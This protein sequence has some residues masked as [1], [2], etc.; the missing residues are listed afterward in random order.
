MR[1]KCRQYDYDDISHD[2]DGL[3][4][5]HRVNEPNGRDDTV[6]G[7][8]A[9]VERDEPSSECDWPGEEEYPIRVSDGMPAAGHAYDVER[10]R[11]KP[12]YHQHG[13]DERH[14]PR[15]KVPC[16]SSPRGYKSG[17]LQSAHFGLRMQELSKPIK[18]TGDY[19][20]AGQ[21]DRF[22]FQVNSNDIVRHFSASKLQPR[23]VA[24]RVY[25]QMF[26]AILVS[27]RSG[28]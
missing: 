27:C 12:N 21:E 16:C 18:L 22:Q 17:R 14:E 19:Q 25:L 13:E 28:G 10:F 11:Q 7:H 8:H 3:D 20:Q 26:V 15:K 1:R 2:S 24:T 4:G 23:S 9:G 5:D 6:D